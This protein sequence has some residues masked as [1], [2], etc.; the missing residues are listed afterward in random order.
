[1]YSK[2]DNNLINYF[3]ILFIISR[4]LIYQEKEKHFP[5]W[6]WKI[7]ARHIFSLPLTDGEKKN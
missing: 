2:L 3:E 5:M 1:M 7:S 6:W 4:C